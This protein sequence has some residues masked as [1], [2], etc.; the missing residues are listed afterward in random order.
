[1]KREGELST[2]HYLVVGSDGGGGCR[3]DLADSN[4]LGGFAGNVWQRN[5]SERSSTYV[6]QSFGCIPREVGDIGSEWAIFG[7]SIA[8]VADSKT[9]LANHQTA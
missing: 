9:I 2:D 3:S 1:M 8:E 7:T 5:L 4:V 6:R